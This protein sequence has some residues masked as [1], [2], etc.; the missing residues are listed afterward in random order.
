MERGHFLFPRRQAEDRSL[1]RPRRPR[2]PPP[3]LPSSERGPRT[4]RCRR[5]RR[6]DAASALFRKR[7]RK[8]QACSEE[9]LITHYAPGAGHGAGRGAQVLRGGA[10]QRATLGALWEVRTGAAS[11][12]PTPAGSMTL[13][14]LAGRGA[15]G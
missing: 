9:S 2:S 8:L 7:A 5:K 4:R 1:H 10:E 14:W 13:R 6:V 3:C 11:L 15:V 12:A